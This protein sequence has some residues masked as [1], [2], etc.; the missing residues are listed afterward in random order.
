MIVKV[1]TQTKPKRNQ[2][3]EHNYQQHYRE[4]AVMEN[5]RNHFNHS[6]PVMGRDSPSVRNALNP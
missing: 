4:R 1:A 6:M 2:N 3:Y 5:D